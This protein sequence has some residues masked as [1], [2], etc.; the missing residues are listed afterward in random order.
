MLP[1]NVPGSSSHA[2]QWLPSKNLLTND[3][4]R[5][6]LSHNYHFHQY[7]H[8]V[9]LN[10]LHWLRDGRL[11]EIYRTPLRHPQIFHVSPSI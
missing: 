9:G 4:L 11:C 2:P 10:L 7:V 8:G 6:S 1:S 3:I 5:L